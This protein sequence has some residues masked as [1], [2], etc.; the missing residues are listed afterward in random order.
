MIDKAGLTPHDGLALLKEAGMEA[1]PGGGA[2]I[3]DEAIRARICPEKGSSETWL[4]MHREAHRIGISTNATILYGHVENWEHRIDHL[5][6]L[7]TLQ[8]ETGGFNAFIPLKYRSRHNS[9]SEVGEVSVVEDMRMTA[10]ARIYL[11]NFPH[12]KA[13]WPMFGKTTAQ[14]ALAFGADDMDG[15]IDDSTKIYSMAGAEDQSP[16]M[17]A[18]DMERL[19]RDAGYLPV[20]RDTFYNPVKK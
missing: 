10:L 6:R 12:I 16:A 18:A 2:E 19:I 13:Y 5:D 1:I 20:E 4:A 8:D 15:T 17:T 3:F 7:R 9:M 14:I 11:D